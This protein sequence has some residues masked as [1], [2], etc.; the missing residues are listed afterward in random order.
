M[1]GM[2]SAGTREMTWEWVRMGRNDLV[3]I[4]DLGMALKEW[5]QEETDSVGISSKV[6]A[7]KQ[8][9]GQEWV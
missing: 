2:V 8:S 9:L 7:P 5:F 1:A 3:R 6:V 4:P